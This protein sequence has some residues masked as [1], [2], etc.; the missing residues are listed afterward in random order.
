MI[1][2]QSAIDLDLSPEERRLVLEFFPKGLIAIGLQT[3]GLSPL[4]DRIIE[5][6]AVKIGRYSTEVFQSLIN[7]EIEIP[8]HTTEIHHITDDMVAS[9]P[10]SR[11]VLIGLLDFFGDLP[12]VAHN[13]KFD[14]G[15]IVMGFNKWN[16]PVGNNDIYCS[17]KL[18]RHTHM[19]IKNHK[20]S[21]LVSELNIPLLNHHRAFDDAF[22][23]LKVFVDSLRRAKTPLSP[24]IKRHGHLFNLNQFEKFEILDLPD[25]LAALEKLV[26][27]AAVIE[28]KYSG[29][30]HKNEFRPV[31]LTSL[32]NTPDG[33]ILSA[34]CLWS[35]LQKSFKL[36]KVVE[37]RTP[38]A[39]DIQKW[40]K[41]A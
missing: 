15:F 22:A 32:M 23:S 30:N 40:L 2:T 1:K 37:I 35:D 26:K 20:L 7:P 28:L 5:V 34:R 39:E 33:N 3:T 11:E 21:T 12:I 13:A 29:G 8:P 9:S 4:V 36:S 41:K 17:C 25:H 10:K 24:I 38:T 14:L 19:E 31:K 18:A 6:A 27:E 16:I